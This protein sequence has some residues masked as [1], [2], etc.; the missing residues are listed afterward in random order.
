MISAA[1]AA[2]LLMMVAPAASA[3]AG[4]YPDGPS[5][6]AAPIVGNWG[7]AWA[8]LW[9]FFAVWLGW[10]VSVASYAVGKV[11]RAREKAHK[12]QAGKVRRASSVVVAT[13]AERFSSA[14]AASSKH[15]AWLRC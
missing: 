7:E 1:T 10:A 13:P 2:L 4:G 12:K 8:V 9:P 6:K 5:R 14:E 11:L 3:V 15:S